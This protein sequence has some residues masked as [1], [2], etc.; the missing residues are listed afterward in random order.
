MTYDQAV[1]RVDETIRLGLCALKGRRRIAEEV[2]TAI[3]FVEVLEER[4]RLRFA[5][6]GHWTARQLAWAE[7]EL[8]KMGEPV[9][10]AGLRSLGLL[11]G[12][13]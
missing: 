2:L 8:R 7:D 4:D 6:D 11:G 10:V 12:S 3:A 1:E 9:D 5:V 13:Q